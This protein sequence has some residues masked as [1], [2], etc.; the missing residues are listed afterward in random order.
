MGCGGNSNQQSRGAAAPQGVMKPGQ[1]T[2]SG[3]ILDTP[4]RNIIMALQFV[5]KNFTYNE[6]KTIKE[7]TLDNHIQTNPPT[8][9]TDKKYLNIC[10]SG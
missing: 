10:P 3:N 8:F 9:N 1:I 2:V 7:K 5:G 6:V 4:T